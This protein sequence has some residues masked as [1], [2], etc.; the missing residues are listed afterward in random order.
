[1]RMSLPTVNYRTS[2]QLRPG[3]LVEYEL[4]KDY[5]KAKGIKV[6]E[7]ILTIG[8]VIRVDWAPLNRRSRV[9]IISGEDTRVIDINDIIKVHII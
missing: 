6:K 8:L 7:H 5:H 9:H 3:S 1:M 4:K 2:S